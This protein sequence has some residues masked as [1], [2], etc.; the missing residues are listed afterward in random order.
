MLAVTSNHSLSDKMKS[1][2]E[3]IKHET[4]ITFA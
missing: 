2:F 4:M 3:K 1:A